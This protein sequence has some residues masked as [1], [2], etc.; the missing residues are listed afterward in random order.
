MRLVIIPF[1]L[2]FSLIT[3]KPVSGQQVTVYNFQQDDT[4]LKRTYYNQ[5]LEQKNSLVAGLDKQYKTDYKEIYEERFK[6]VGGLLLSSRSVTEPAANNYLQSILQ[7]II[8]VNP[9]LSGRTLRLV[10][11]RD[12]WPNAYSMG[13]GTIAFNA[14]LLVFLHNEAEL[15]FILCHELAHDYLN[16][17]N[18]AIRQQVETVNSE[19]FKQEMKRLG[20][21]E[22]RAGQQFEQLVKKLAFGNRRH[23]RT[24]EA[25]A[26]AQ[27]FGF[28]KKTG[29]DCNAST[30]CLQLLDKVDDSAL[31]KPLQLQE[32]FN[33]PD[34][35]F[36]QRWIEK[37]SAIFGQMNSDESPVLNKK[38]KDSLK[39]HPDCTQRI[40]LLKDS[41]KSVPAGKNF[42]VNETLLRQL[43][44]DFIVEMTEQGFKSDHLGQHLYFS[45]LML[46]N[47]TNLPYATYAVARCLNRVYTL[48]KQHRLGL[49]MDKEARGYP[50]DYNLL[51]RFADKLK[52]DELAELAYQFCHQHEAAMKVY[53]V[54]EKEL[55][56]AIKNRTNHQ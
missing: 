24:N 39:T 20:K 15:V 32:I 42:L 31:F 3:S 2:L 29:Y 19:D 6:A 18:N 40:K 51:L 7:K 27:A 44:K 28:M 33:F 12:A 48:Q 35:A 25:A 8:M 37:E 11:T 50:D 17:G 9:E 55:S 4:L 23:S 43:Q 53:P 46:Q 54:F 38:E 16:H 10:F 34:Y 21:Q 36:R 47:G 1:L 13:E 56:T 14:G 49:S 30:T 41:V 22:Y 45:L 5:A 26:D 52:L